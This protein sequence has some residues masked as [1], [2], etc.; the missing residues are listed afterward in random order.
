MIFRR[1]VATLVVLGAAPIVGDGALAVWRDGAWV[2]WY[3]DARAPARW[4]APLEMLSGAVTWSA[5]APGVEMG[6]LRL[7]GSGE[8][9][10]VGVVLL[11]IDPTKVR[12]R[13][14]W[15]TTESAR[16]N[17]AIEAADTSALVSLNAGMFTG[18]GPFGWTVVDGEERGVAASGALAPAFVVDSAGVAALVPAES[19]WTRS[20]QGGVALAFQS[21][22]ELLHG[23]GDVPPMLRAGA[24]AIDLTHRD[25]RLAI[26][27]LRDGKWLIALTRFE[28]AG[29]A[30]SFL[31]FGLTVPEM[32]ALMGALGCRRAVSL[33]GGVSAQLRVGKE[34]WPGLRKVALGLE[35][36]P[37]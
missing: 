24:T 4:D 15:G 17:W 37:R 33:D 21:Y 35:V 22:P 7:S 19:L 12:W 8:A 36:L 9:W 6:R 29:G 5:T 14:R 18:L 25:A 10:R 20:R 2:T 23:E 30:L 27:Q 34:R 13:L 26:G 32:S 1:V 3:D 11:R 31:P 28:G 16:K